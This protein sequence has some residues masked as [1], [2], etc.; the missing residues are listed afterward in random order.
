MQ[1]VREQRRTRKQNLRNEKNF[2]KKRKKFLTNGVTRD[3]IIQL[4][5]QRTKFSL[6][7]KFEKT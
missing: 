7:K 1:A 2:S 5:R 4:S 3:K 6:E